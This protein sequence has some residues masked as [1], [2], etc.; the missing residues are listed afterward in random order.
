MCNCIK[1][2]QEKIQELMSIQIPNSNTVAKIATTTFRGIDVLPITID[3]TIDGNKDYSD[4]T[5]ILPSYCAFC[6]TKI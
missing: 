6:G 5:L 2:R 1:E 4:R 3:L